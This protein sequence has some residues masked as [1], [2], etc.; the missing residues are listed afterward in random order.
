MSHMMSRSPLGMFWG[1][2]KLQ[3]HKESV[4]WSS[5]HCFLLLGFLPVRAAVRTLAG[6]GILCDACCCYLQGKP[7]RGTVYFNFLVIVS[8]QQELNIKTYVYSVTFYRGILSALVC[9]FTEFVFK[10]LLQNTMVSKVSGICSRDFANLRDCTTNS[11]VILW[12]RDLSLMICLCW[13]NTLG[14]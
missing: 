11:C 10:A 4:W 14:L 2:G 6:D 1:L 9:A 13:H 7:R 8:V 5:L 3:W 12:E